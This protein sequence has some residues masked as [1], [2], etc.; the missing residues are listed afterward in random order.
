MGRSGSVCGK[1][2]IHTI[3]WSKHITRRNILENLGIE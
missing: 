2:E 1:E 3:F